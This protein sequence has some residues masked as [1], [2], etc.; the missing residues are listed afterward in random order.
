MC[1]WA[2]FYFWHRAE[3]IFVNKGKK[4]GIRHCIDSQQHFFF[5]V[6]VQIS[7]KP[8]PR[9]SNRRLLGKLVATV[10]SV[11]LGCMERGPSEV[12]LLGAEVVLAFPH[13]PVQALGQA[14][15]P[16]VDGVP[17]ADGGHGEAGRGDANAVSVA[18]LLTLPSIE[19]H[20]SCMSGITRQHD[21][22]LHPGWHHDGPE[23][24]RVGAD[25]G[26]HDGGNIGVDHGGSGGHSISGAAGGRG[27]DHTVSLHCGDEVSVQEQVHVGQI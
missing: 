24:Q 10:R 20:P 19:R 21:L 6:Y 3:L 5:A 15:E 8:S 12:V 26:N 4:S 13:V 14:L 16:V 7:Q 18:D 27:H 22:E 17:E 9:V 23:G 25:G 1:K 2:E 11:K